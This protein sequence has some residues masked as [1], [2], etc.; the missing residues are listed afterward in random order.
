MQE[1][2]Y[3]KI[4]NLHPHHDNPR[5]ELGDLTELADSIKANGVLQNLTVVP[6]EREMTADEYKEACEVYR[7]NPSENTQRTVNQHKIADGYTVLIGHR[8]LAAAKLAGLS[9]LPCVVVSMD[10][11]EQIR[12]M[13]VENM[14]RADLTVYEQAQGFQMMLDLGDSVDTIAKKS[15]FSQSTVRRRVKLLELDQEKFAASVSRG[16][17]MADY[18]ELD[19]I[20]DTCL[21]NQV[22]DAIGTNNFRSQLQQ[23]IYTEKSRE[24]VAKCVEILNTFATKLEKIDGHDVS[25]VRTYGQYNGKELPAVPENAGSVKYFYCIGSHTSDVTLYC[26]R[27]AE[28]KNSVNDEEERIKKFWDDRKILLTNASEL[29][30]NLRYDFVKQLSESEAKQSKPIMEP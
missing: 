20:K 29:A 21:K 19:K 9:E 7:K 5:K 26:E 16:A 27:G 6:C 12:T 14:Q 23:A 22:L 4:E 17:T 25:Y 11:S 15:G 18:M 8:R 28:K 10:H 24:Y 3:I 30:Y 2:K 1:L 13:L